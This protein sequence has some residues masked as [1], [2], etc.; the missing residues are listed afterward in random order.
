MKESFCKYKKGDV[1][2]TASGRGIVTSTTENS[3]PDHNGNPDQ[4]M[5]GVRLDCAPTILHMPFFESELELVDKP[6]ERKSNAEF[7]TFL[8]FFAFAL[9]A[10]LGATT[11]VVI[12]IVEL[13]ILLF[14][15]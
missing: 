12:K 9:A 6:L 1:V 2:K 13:I 4:W 5:V 8:W 15:R 14:T 3:L 11:M 7:K 10:I